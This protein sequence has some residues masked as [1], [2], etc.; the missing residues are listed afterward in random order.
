MRSHDIL[1]LYGLTPNLT[2]NLY[3]TAACLDNHDELD[4]DNFAFKY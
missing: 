2:F 4:F 1:T 3:S